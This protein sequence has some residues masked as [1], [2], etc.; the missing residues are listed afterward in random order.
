MAYLVQN[1]SDIGVNNHQGD[2]I[3][4][5]IRVADIPNVPMIEWKPNQII[6]L[7]Y[8]TT[9]AQIE[10]STHLRVHINEGRLTKLP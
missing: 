9:L 8:F 10:Q 1:T 3:Q 5:T 2:P 4:N 6:D 7:E